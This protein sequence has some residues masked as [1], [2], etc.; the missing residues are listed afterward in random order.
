MTTFSDPVLHECLIQ[1]RAWRDIV[2]DV[3]LPGTDALTVDPLRVHEALL[4][5][6]NDA[7]NRLAHLMVAHGHADTIADAVPLLRELVAYAECG[8]RPRY[9]AEAGLS[10]GKFEA[11]REERS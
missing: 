1:Y 4:A 9:A 8:R 10:F 5:L 3:M 7:W 6:D 11:A 2:D